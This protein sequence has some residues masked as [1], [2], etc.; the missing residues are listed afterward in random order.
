M[1]SYK[2]KL[3]HPDD[4]DKDIHKDDMSYEC[5]TGWQ[6]GC[7]ISSGVELRRNCGPRLGSRGNGS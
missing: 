7:S 4:S 5:S 3:Y 1:P 2:L 6:G